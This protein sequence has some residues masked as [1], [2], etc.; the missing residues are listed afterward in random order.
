MIQRT[1]SKILISTQHDARHDLPFAQAKGQGLAALLFCRIEDL[2]V[3]Q[4][5]SVVD[6]DVRLGRGVAAAER[7]RRVDQWATTFLDDHIFRAAFCGSYGVGVDLDV[8]ARCQRRECC[9]CHRAADVSTGEPPLCR[10][11]GARRRDKCD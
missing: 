9:E 11:Q 3:R 8:G 6:R 1:R 10:G 7:A 5:A 2:A 4:E